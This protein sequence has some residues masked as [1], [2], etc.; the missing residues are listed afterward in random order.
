LVG[1]AIL[2]IDATLLTVRLLGWLSGMDRAFRE[3][4]RR[5]TL[6]K[7]RPRPYSTFQTRV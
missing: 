5:Q 6:H 7:S 2:E 4:L 3:D 1:T